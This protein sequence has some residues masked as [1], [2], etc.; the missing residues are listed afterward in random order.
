[1]TK[2]LVELV[3]RPRTFCGAK[4]GS[5]KEMMGLVI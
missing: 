1:M 3:F 4:L 2:M 5:D